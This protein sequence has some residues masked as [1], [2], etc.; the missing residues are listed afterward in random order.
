MSGEGSTEREGDGR[1]WEGPSSPFVV[2]HAGVASSL[3]AVIVVRRSSTVV[4]PSLSF[5]RF[6]SWAS[7]IACLGKG[8]VD[9]TRCP[10]P[11]G[12]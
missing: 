5:L 2:V 9:G 11:L 7:G 8:A 10:L 3:L 1:W 6:A 4:V 12:G